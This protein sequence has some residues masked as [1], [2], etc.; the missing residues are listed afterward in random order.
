MKHLKENLGRVEI[1][2]AE[3]VQQQ[4]LPQDTE[5]ISAAVT[6]ATASIQTQL[7]NARA[8]AKTW[9]AEVNRLRTELQNIEAIKKEIEEWK[10]KA[11][12]ADEELESLKEVRK[13]GSLL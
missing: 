8:E 2:K 5:A 1:P 9:S 7:D 4:P 10:S 6:V 11:E 13:H 3:A 12:K